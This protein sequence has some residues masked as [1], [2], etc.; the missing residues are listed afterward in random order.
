[1]VDDKKEIHEELAPKKNQVRSVVRKVARVIKKGHAKL[2]A[3]VT[4][5]PKTAAYFLEI[6]CI[7]AVA[8]VILLFSGGKL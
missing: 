2:V 8:A 5:C 4:Q 3:A 1:M 6:W 7:L